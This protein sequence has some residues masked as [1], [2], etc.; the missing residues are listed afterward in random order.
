MRITRLFNNF[1]TSQF[2]GMEKKSNENIHEVIRLC[3]FKI[4]QMPNQLKIIEEFD[5]PYL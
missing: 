3:L 4:T 1:N 5:P 2:Q